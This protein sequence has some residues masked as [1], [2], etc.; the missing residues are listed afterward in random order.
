MGFDTDIM[1]GLEV[2]VV[3][4]FSSRVSTL[5]RRAAEVHRK[6]TFLRGITDNNRCI[7]SRCFG[8]TLAICNRIAIRVWVI[9]VQ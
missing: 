8:D 3:E 7:H 1:P 4:H 5:E 9:V 6:S 2:L